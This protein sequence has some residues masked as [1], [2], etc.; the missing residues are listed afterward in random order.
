MNKKY[1]LTQ[2]FGMYEHNDDITTMNS[3]ALAY[4][5]K[6]VLIVGDKTKTI[7]S[8]NGYTLFGQTGL[9]GNSIKTKYDDFINVAGK[10]LWIRDEGVSGISNISVLY[11][12]LWH[13]IAGGITA[14]HE[15]YFTEWQD[16]F[17]GVNHLIWVNGDSL[18]YYWTGGISSVSTTS[19]TTI[20]FDDN[21]IT[22]LPNTGSVNMNGIVYS[23]TGIAGQTLTGVT[24]NP[25][26][27]FTPGDVMTSFAQVTTLENLGLPVTTP[28]LDIC[29]VLDNHV[30]YGNYKNKTIWVSHSRNVPSYYT[31][32]LTN[33]QYD[34]LIVS[35]TYTGTIKKKVCINVTK[36]TLSEK[37]TSLTV[38][39]PAFSYIGD[40]IIPTRGKFKTIVTA[41]TPGVSVTVDVFFQPDYT[42]PFPGVPTNTF[43][44]T[45][46]DI[47]S[48]FDIGATGVR[49]FVQ[50]ISGSVTPPDTYTLEVGGA[51]EY[52]YDVLDENG[53]VIQSGGPIPMNNSFTIDG[54][55]F[56]WNDFEDHKVG[57]QWCYTLYPTVSHGFADI[58]ADDPRKATQGFV[59][60]IDSPPIA[61]IPQEHKMYINSRNGIWTN[62]EFKLAAENGN[63]TIIF[64]RLKSEY[65]NKALR[66][67]MV[68]HANN[69]IYYVT[70]D[71]TVDS[72]G[73]VEGIDTPQ[74]KPISNPIK[75]DIKNAN[76]T[77]NVEGLN[78]GHLSFVDN[79]LILTEPTNNTIW[80]FDTIQGGWQPPQEYPVS[81]ISSIN[82]DVIGHSN[83]QDES[84]KLFNSSNDNG[85][86]FV[87]RVVF[88]YNNYGYRYDK[89]SCDTLFTEAY[90]NSQSNLAIKFYE[91]YGGCQAI[92]TERLDPVICQIQ[93]RASL[94]KGQL[95][96]HSLGNDPVAY[97]NKFRT[98]TKLNPR[99]WYES[100]IVYEQDS[101]DGYFRLVS[102]GLNADV[103]SC[104]NSN[105][106]KLANT[107]EPEYYPGIP[108]TEGYSNYINPGNS[109]TGNGDGIIDGPGTSGNIGG[110]PVSPGEDTPGGA[111]ST[112]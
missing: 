85:L 62:A 27:G 41:S 81:C 34:N 87:S 50:S 11:N 53:V 72:L 110:T 79:K 28:Q 20:T 40:Y 30:F 43:T 58:Y 6:N 80:I 70:V 57:D 26:I 82:G 51:D 105:L 2:D 54:V 38:G 98:T 92:S 68:C 42:L 76:F 89:K 12:G 66:Q 46:T 65:T 44:F 74:S 45:P 75:V 104:N 96:S 37:Q 77:P 91:E 8:R 112:P 15:S 102:T 99:C 9:L 95:G 71:N 101:I 48:S 21:I 111:P 3:N 61:M 84:Y 18:I 100:S 63:Q 94:G 73:R 22:A 10:K 56:S 14:P 13:R 55:T 4:G 29:S 16:T 88:P 33:T 108:G 49:L 19:P 31:N 86:P 36:T 103:G 67:S 93:D 39:G 83:I 107:P 5:T 59:W 106:C 32:T 25:T 52:K 17:N 23:Y 7:E 90:K 109:I 47:G 69:D 97:I 24:P 35:G 60:I 1:T 78:L 64:D